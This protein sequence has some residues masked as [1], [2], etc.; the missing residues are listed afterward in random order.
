MSKKIETYTP[1][2]KEAIIVVGDPVFGF[3]FYGPF[4]SQAEAREWQMDNSKELDAGSDWWVAPLE[5]W[6]EDVVIESTNM[7]IILPAANVKAGD[8]S[9][10]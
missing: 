4:G 1:K 8:I 2:N 5:H 7:A 3:L 9:D 10:I 6:E